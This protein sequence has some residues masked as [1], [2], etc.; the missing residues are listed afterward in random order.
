[1]IIDCV[2]FQTIGRSNLDW[3]ACLHSF[4]SALHSEANAVL[5]SKSRRCTAVMI[6]PGKQ[7][8]GLNNCDHPF[9]PRLQTKRAPGI[10]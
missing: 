6:T 9:A 7:G 3:L 2:R 8:D 4:V 10:R 1:M 5:L